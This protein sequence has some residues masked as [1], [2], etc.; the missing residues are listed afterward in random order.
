MEFYTSVQPV[1]D[2]IFVRG[3]ENGKPYRR[4]IDFY[5]TLYV[6]SKD[7]VSSKWRTL[8]NNIV[9]EVR[10]GTI[11]ETR[12]F[13]KR[14]SDVSGFDIYGQTNYAYQYISDNYPEEIR[15]DMDHIKVFTID[16]ETSTE[17]GFPDIKSAN[18]EVLLITVKDLATKNVTTFGYSP[19][20]DLHNNNRDNVDYRAF[21]SELSMLKE[22]MIWWQENYPDIITGWNTDFF[23]VPYLV[24]RVDRELGE[25]FSKKFS[26]WGYINERKTF[27]KGSEEIHYTIMG[28][29]QL[30][31][32]QLYQKY[33]YS[34]Q[35]SYR[36]DYI[37]EQE[38][39]SNKLENPGSTF[40]EFYTQYWDKFV[41]YNIRD[42]ELVDQ[43]EDKMRLIELHLTM[44]YNAGINYEDVFS[45]VRMWDT[46]IYNHLRKKNIVIPQKTDSHKDAQFEGAYVKD[47]LVGKHNWVASFDLNSL[48]PHLIMQYNISPETLTSEKISCTVDK[49]LNREVDTSYAHRRDLS[50]TANGWCYTKEFQGFM[51]ELM[52][53]MYVNRSK[54]KKQMLK[55]EQEYQHDKSKVQLL[56]EISRLTNLQMA[57]KI[58][59]NS[60]YGAMGN[61]YFR[62]FDL[63]MAEGI[64][65][66]GQLS[67]R[68]M[69]NK[70]NAFMNKTLKTEGQDFVIA[71]DTD[72]IYLTLES[73][74]EK[75][76]PEKSTEDKIKYMDKICEDIFQPFID[77]GYQ[78]LADYMNAYSQKMVMKR[79]VLA[80][81]AIWT[82]K[83]RYVM[84][85]HN[86]EGVQYAKPKVKVMGLEMV[87]SST[88][89]VIRDKLR[90]AIPV[91]LSGDKSKLHDFVD[92]F[93]QQFQKLPVDAIA[94]P[95]SVGDIKKY[96]GSPIYTK[97]TPIHIRGALLFNHHVKRFGLENKYQPIRSG[98]K[99]KFVYVKKPNPFQEDIIAFPSEL[100]KEFELTSYIDYDKQ[101]EKTFI[102]AIQIVIEPLGWRAQEEAN[103][104][105]FFG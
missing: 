84:N 23:D 95:R 79:E 99:I 41:E 11:K 4:K 17:H 47:P 50:M 5:P 48:Y 18:E 104:E 80:D 102:D 82:A 63:R 32:L 86:S 55:V 37:A 22:F 34:K 45:Q 6:N 33:T 96:S 36:L 60:A 54:F 105:E 103:L 24:R 100:P 58:A 53:Q 88:P 15:F 85:V 9:D 2:K 91:I 81:T 51:P 16:I 10:P 8:E 46:I 67:I 62:Y 25:S 70:L 20:G 92:S 75:V 94:F 43:L 65:T 56:K 39:G 31:Y 12:D 59:L 78:E 89:A 101:F 66:S 68:W 73:L 27:I 77:S 26:P 44:A 3:Y 61:Q 90:D 64:T 13:V 69:A 35:E 76:C 52:N 74:I 57:M 19:T 40:K 87:K 28:I 97:G 14:Y 49:L 83:K 98:D 29:A 72:S 7:Q 71:I 42:V 21:T 93:R 38:L 1:G 30:D